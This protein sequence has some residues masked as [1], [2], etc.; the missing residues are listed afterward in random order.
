MGPVLPWRG[1]HGRGHVGHRSEFPPP[2]YGPTRKHCT[3]ARRRVASAAPRPPGTWLCSPVPA[4]TKSGSLPRIARPPLPPA[5]KP[6]WAGVHT[7]FQPMAWPMTCA[8]PT[9]SGRSRCSCTRRKWASCRIA[10]RNP[11]LLPPTFTLSTVHFCTLSIFPLRQVR[12]SAVPAWEVSSVASRLSRVAVFASSGSASPP[13]RCLSSASPVLPGRL[14]P[15]GGPESGPVS[16]LGLRASG[17]AR[18]SPGVA[19]PNPLLPVPGPRPVC[20]VGSA[21]P[22]AL[23]CP[24]VAVGI[25]SPLRPAGGSRV[26]PVPVP[27]PGAPAVARPPFSLS[28]SLLSTGALGPRLS[29]PLRCLGHAAS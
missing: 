27:G 6:C 9:W 21:S 13:G 25:R 29:V 3:G 19:G 11:S 28:G 12:P 26:D 23:I 15:S 18:A 22:P 2:G 14:R 1:P 5:R 8:P 20:V 16:T 24:G 17:V 10:Q 4:T 7:P